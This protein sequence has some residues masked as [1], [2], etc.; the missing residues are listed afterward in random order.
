MIVNN[1]NIRF[2]V[3]PLNIH[4][5]TWVGYLLLHAAHLGLFIILMMMLRNNNY[6]YEKKIIREGVKK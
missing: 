6:H 5:L 2:N 3:E 4:I 1:R